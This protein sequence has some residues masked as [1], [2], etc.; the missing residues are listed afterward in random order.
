MTHTPQS[1]NCPH[2]SPRCA[3]RLPHD[4]GVAMVLVMVALVV[5]LI[6]AMGF[7]ARQS[8]SAG[9]T[10]N[11][12]AHSQARLIA[13]SA[14]ELAIAHVQQTAD[15][16]ENRPQGA[17]VTDAP[18]AGGTYTIE[19]YDGI[20]ENGDGVIDGDGSFTDDLTDPIT[21]IGR[22][23]V[24]GVTHQVVARINSSAAAVKTLLL[25]VPDA[26]DLDNQ[27]AEKQRLI[28]SWNYK[29]RTISADATPDTLDAAVLDADVI[30]ISE[31][32]NAGKLYH[33]LR[34]ATIGAVIEEPDLADDFRICWSYRSSQGTTIYISDNTH[35][36]TAP[37][38]EGELAITSNSNPLCEASSTLADGARVLGRDRPGGSATVVAVEASADLLGSHVAAGRRVMLPWGGN[39][40]NVFELNNNGRTI[41]RRAIEWA[42][43]QP[44]ARPPIS[45][46]L[47][48]EV[49]GKAAMDSV[50]SRHGEYEK[51]PRLGEPGIHNTAVSFDGHKDHLVINHDD[52]MLLE[53]GTFSFWVKPDSLSGRQGLLSKD[54]TG[55]DDGG[56]LTMYLDGDE[57]VTRLQSRWWSYEVQSDDLFE[58]DQWHHVAVT[59]GSTRLRLYVD[60][61]MVDNSG[62][63]GGLDGS[64]GSPGNHEPLVIAANAWNSDDG[65]ANHLKEYFDG[66]I[67]D[68]RLYDYGL[69]SAEIQKIYQEGTDHEAGAP[70]L[71]GLYEFEEVIFQPQ[72]IAHWPLDDTHGNDAAE[73]V[74]GLEGRY[75]RGVRLGE[76][77][78]GGGIAPQFDGKND[79]VELPHDPRF[80]LDQGAVGFYFKTN[81]RWDN[82]GLFSKDSTGYDN[83]GHL[84]IYLNGGR[85][86]VRLQNDSWG[87]YIDSRTPILED[88]WY[89]VMFTFG[90][91]GMRL[92]IDGQLDRDYA[93]FTSGLGASS[94]GTGNSEPIAIGANAW[95]SDDESIWDNHSHLDGQIDDVRIYD[96]QLSHEQ[97]ADVYHGR[98]MTPS[99]GPG[100][101]VLDNSGFGDPLNLHINDVRYIDWLEDGGLE[102]D[103]RTIIAS[104]GAATKVRQ[105]LAATSE[106]TVYA[107]VIPKQLGQGGPARIATISGDGQRSSFMLGQSGHSYAA[108]LHTTSTGDN[109]TPTVES[110]RVLGN[111]R[112]QHLMMTYDGEY[113]RIYHDGILDAARARSGSFDNW[114]P[115]QLMV[116]ANNRS[117]WADWRGKLYRVAVYD[118]ALNQLQIDDVLRGDEPGTYNEEAEIQYKVN[119]IESP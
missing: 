63:T 11:I 61:K 59:F 25:V 46:W 91:R 37:F 66:V 6:L 64:S 110:P 105:A 48:D 30:Y 23:Q 69:S 89:H 41:M 79:V 49:T 29:V 3:D 109:G 31:Q 102:V 112:L 86:A 104:S 76:E 108:R 90:P 50:G 45:H 97:V 80:L 13:E 36:I 21:L 10:E 71:V 44:Q 114:D 17:W 62:Y 119:W 73:V 2:R 53:D 72:L 84:T 93:N 58:T 78:Y 65:K 22:G 43:Q 28:E 116:L 106:L 38:A 100:T 81:E 7:L 35:H 103:G 12:Q 52:G 26:H 115:D 18:M 83:G 34:S 42:A 74:G 4:A 24:D 94:G 67:D 107:L 118:R 57:L 16:R 87:E 19:G 75:H 98:T 85:V 117:G 101:D 96:R 40:F 14:L 113:V 88:Q 55:Y 9:V 8:T 27:D 5:A 111:D 60:G 70:Q 20:D 95:S 39:A 47:L 99:T 51:S 33:K 54:S 1:Q 77:G 32:V 15:W 56:H 82:Q 92:Y 68:L